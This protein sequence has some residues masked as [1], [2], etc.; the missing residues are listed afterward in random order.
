MEVH[1]V[2]II[3]EHFYFQKI[4]SIVTNFVKSCHEC[5]SKKITKAH[6]KSDIIS[7]NTPTQPFQV[8]QMDL[9]GPLSISNRGNSYIFTAV[10][11]FSKLLFTVPIRTSDSI[12]VYYALFELIMYYGLMNTLIS[13]QGSEFISQCTKHLCE[14][15]RIHQHFTPAFIH[16]CLGSCERTHRTLAERMTPYISQGKQW[17]DILSAITFAINS[18][19]NTSTNYSPYEA[20]YGFRPIS[21]CHLHLKIQIF[22]GLHQDYHSY[23][24]ELIKILEI[25]RSELTDNAEKHGN[26]MKDRCN[27]KV[28][29]LV[30]NTG[31]YVYLL[32]GA[33]GPGKKLQH[34][35]AGPFVVK[36]ITSPHMITL[37]DPTTDK[38]VKPVHI[39]RLKVVYV[40]RQPNPIKYFV[41]KVVTGEKQDSS[42]E[43]SSDNQSQ[44]L[45]DKNETPVDTNVEGKYSDDVVF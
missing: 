14:M 19:V 18:P 15:L 5:Q 10:D 21:R 34:K 4:P 33:T 17:D 29:K 25:I 30:L 41:P 45:R 24:R 35:Y 36:E 16:H 32:K 9:V 11:L 26:L 3:S 22:N 40:L 6:T 43:N 12:T 20:L 44:E 7:F 27:K 42:D 38:L 28:N 1:T 37:K 13:D 2:D 23:M 31:D 39:D 8:W